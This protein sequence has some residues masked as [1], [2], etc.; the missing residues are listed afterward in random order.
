[1]AVFAEGGDHAAAAV[2]A[3][4]RMQKKL[5]EMRRADP[6]LRNL[7]MRI[8]INTGDVVAGNIGSQTR[9]EYTV[10]GDNVNVASRIEGACVPDRVL[11]SASTWQAAK[12]GFVAEEQHPIRVKNRSEAVKTFLIRGFAAA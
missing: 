7:Q 11:V 12:E 4:V 8:G 10:I 2:R 1:M 9:M 6:A 3:G 5:E